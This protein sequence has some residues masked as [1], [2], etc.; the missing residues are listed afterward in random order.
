MASGT[1]KKTL[2][3]TV[4][5]GIGLAL[6]RLNYPLDAILLCVRWYAAY[7]TA[8]LRDFVGADR[9]GSVAQEAFDGVW[10]TSVDLCDAAN[11]AARCLR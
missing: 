4:A 7:G 8:S 6:K 11:R 10:V 5:P 3:K 1:G 2:R 9:R